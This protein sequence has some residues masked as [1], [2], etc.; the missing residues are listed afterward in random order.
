M[1]ASPEGIELIKRF[2]GLRLHAYVCSGGKFTIGYGHT[3]GVCAGDSCT[4]EDAHEYLA[5]DV[6]K[7]EECVNRFV[8][9]PLTQGEFDALVSFAFNLGCGALSGSTLLKKL[10]AGDKDGAAD[11]F[12]RWTK[13]GGRELTGLVLRREAEREVFLA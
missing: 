8:T 6:A 4:E 2:E 3:F 13:A 10:N 11:E 1:R 12:L 7:F 9:V 5:E